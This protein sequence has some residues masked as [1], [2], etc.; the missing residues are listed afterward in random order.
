LVNVC[1][2]TSFSLNKNIQ[3]LTK[4]IIRSDDYLENLVML[5]KK[6]LRFCIICQEYLTWYQRHHDF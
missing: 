1:T 3:W 4:N 5:L 2:K 6:L